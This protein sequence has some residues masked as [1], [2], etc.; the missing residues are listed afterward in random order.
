LKSIATLKTT[1]Y[2]GAFPKSLLRKQKAFLLGA[3]FQIFDFRC[4]I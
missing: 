2:T 1:G 4:Q 3:E